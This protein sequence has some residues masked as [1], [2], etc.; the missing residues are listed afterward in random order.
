MVNGIGLQRRGFS[1]K[2]DQCNNVQGSR[3]LRPL[4]QMDGNDKTADR[5]DMV[6]FCQENFV[7][8]QEK[9]YSQNRQFIFTINLW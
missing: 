9:T 8:C 3:D 2:G 5:G 6:A 7:D 4:E 1:E